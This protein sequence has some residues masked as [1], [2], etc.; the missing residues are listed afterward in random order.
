MMSRVYIRI[1]YVSHSPT[2]A[3]L[4]IY[5]FRIKEKKNKQQTDT[6]ES[7]DIF[8]MKMSEKCVRV[9]LVSVGQ[10]TNNFPFF[11]FD[12]AQDKQT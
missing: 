8:S 5:I 2:R 10:I 1:R 12:F 11:S 6:S 9:F 7:E 3:P 4:K